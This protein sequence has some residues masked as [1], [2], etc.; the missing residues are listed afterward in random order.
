MELSLPAFAQRVTVLGST[1][2]IDATSAGVS[3]ASDSGGRVFMATLPLFGFPDHRIPGVPLSPSNRC[4]PHGRP[5]GKYRTIGLS[6]TIGNSGPK[7]PQRDP[8]PPTPPD[9][10]PTR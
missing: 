8:E 2:N 1:R 10:R 3:R 4:V 6:R 9:F 5:V 7:T